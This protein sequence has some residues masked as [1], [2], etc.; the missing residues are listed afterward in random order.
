[1]NFY[2]KN[3]N[4]NLSFDDREGG[5]A[6]KSNEQKGEEMHQREDSEII[7]IHNNERRNTKMERAR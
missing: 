2:K 4:I 7:G 5:E 3:V 6:D 1:M